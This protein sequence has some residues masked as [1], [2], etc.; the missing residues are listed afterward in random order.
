ML[1]KILR[2]VSSL[3]PN[4]RG[5]LFAREQRTPVTVPAM[6]GN[7]DELSGTNKVVSRVCV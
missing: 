5:D 3:P 6:D 1:K 2:T 4:L 7:S